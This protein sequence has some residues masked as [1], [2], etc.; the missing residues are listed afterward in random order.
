MGESTKRLLDVILAMLQ[1]LVVFTSG[2]WIFFRFRR[3][4]THTPRVAFDIDGKF[5]GP[6]AGFYLG[7]FV[8]SVK[9]DGLVRHTFTKINL[10]V[11]GVRNESPVGLWGGTQRVEFPEQIIDDADVMYKKKYGS[12]FVEPGVTQSLTFVARIPVE[13]RFILARAQFEYD[14]R[15]THSAEKVFEIG[16]H[17]SV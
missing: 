9:N 4:G 8:M 12:I 5:F 11:R 17:Q 6:Q 14:S 15:R 2:I 10:R 3:E 16:L 13:M 1:L 7:E